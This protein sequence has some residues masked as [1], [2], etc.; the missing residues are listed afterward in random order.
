MRFSEPKPKDTDS[1]QA[2][3]GWY[4]TEGYVVESQT[5]TSALLVKPEGVFAGLV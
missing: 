4:A 2:H 1:L 5:E 3:I